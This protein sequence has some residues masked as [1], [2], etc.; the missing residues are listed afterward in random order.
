MSEALKKF[1]GDGPYPYP[2]KEFAEAVNMHLTDK[3]IVLQPKTALNF[4]EESHAH[5]SFEFLI[6]GSAMPLAK[7]EKR[8]FQF[9]VNKLF[10]FNSEEFHGPATAYPN[11]RFL[12]FQVDK[13]FMRET[14]RMIYGREAVSFKNGSFAFDHEIEELIRRFIEENVNRQAGYQFI[15]DT[16]GTQVIIKLLRQLRSNMPVL[17][18]ECDYHERNNINRAKDFLTEHSNDDY[19]LEKVAQIANLSPYH[20]LRVFKAQIGRTPYDFLL[21]IKI[22]K[23]CALL[24][25][26]K[27]SITDICYLCGFNSLNHFG[28]VFKRRVGVSPSCYRNSR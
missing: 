12:A 27:F 25:G 7:V 26:H 2:P 9:E 8:L 21:D 22:K 5:E 19:S 6:P 18:R 3:F 15:M 10:V 20:F 13:H 4:V 11:C 16:I 1:L 28:S 24:N 17:T 14:A 23:A